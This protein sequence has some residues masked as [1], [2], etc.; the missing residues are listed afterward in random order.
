MNYDWLLPLLGKP[1]KAYASGPDA[2]DCRT[3]VNAVFQ[4]LY[5]F[6]PGLPMEA[7]PNNADVFE[8]EY[9]RLYK[10]GNW[11]RL[12]A[13]EH[14]AIVLLAQGAKLRHMGIWLS[15]NGGRLLHCS[16]NKG[17]TL[18]PSTALSDYHRVEFYKH[19]GTSD[20]LPR[21]D[22]QS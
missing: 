8:A 5:G 16:E 3:I 4:E 9:A 10:S 20:H 11:E 17:V 2:F 14:G 7:E 12:T 6:D 22:Q 15:V 19:V 13:P 1:W 21:P 18:E